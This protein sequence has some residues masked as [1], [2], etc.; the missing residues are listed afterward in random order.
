MKD[1]DMRSRL[2]VAHSDEAFL[3]LCQSFFWDDGFEVEVAADAAECLATLPEFNPD[4]LML[5]LELRCG[6]SDRI[7]S[8]LRHDPFW[9]APPVLLLL[10][11]ENSIGMADLSVLPVLDCLR[12]PAGLHS[13]RRA[14]RNIQNR[15]PLDNPDMADAASKRQSL[16]CSEQNAAAGF[17]ALSARV[18]EQLQ[19]PAESHRT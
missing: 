18:L 7:V 5:Q 6:G 2:L 16:P 8:Q 10:S 15:Q 12:L 9:R 17:L 13:L 3:D 4:V 14:V 19:P 11:A 1:I